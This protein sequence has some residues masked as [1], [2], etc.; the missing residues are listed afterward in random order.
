MSKH[1]P[2]MAHQNEFVQDLLNF[3]LNNHF[4]QFNGVNY[5]QT[6][7]TSMGAPWAPSYACLHLGMWEETV[8]YSLASFRKSVGIWVCYIDDVLVVWMG[9][10]KELH[11]CIN[12]LNLNDRNIK[13]TYNFD[14]V[15]FPFLDLQNTKEGIRL[16]TSTYHKPTAANTLLQ[17]GSFHPKALI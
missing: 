2:E 3:A 14:C 10:E 4:F 6:S 8:V 5:Q 1:H 9:R 12:K 13:L 17:A 16:V 7:G 11:E 15:S